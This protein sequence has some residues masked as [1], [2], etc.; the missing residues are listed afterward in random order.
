[1]PSPLVHTLLPTALAV[2]SPLRKKLSGADRIKFLL[3]CVVLGN[4][5]DFDLFPVLFDA[6]LWTVVHRWY[7]HNL[8]TFVGLALTGN[9]AFKKLLPQFSSRER[10]LCVLGLIASH[11]VLDGMV[12]PVVP[13]S[14]VPLWWPLSHQCLHMPFQLFPTMTR[15]ETMPGVLGY[16]VA[17]DNWKFVFG[18][19]LAMSVTLWLLLTL[20][21][22]LVGSRREREQGQD[23]R[24]DAGSFHGK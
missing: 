19:E 1:M 20:S 24:G 8:F 17:A 5:P 12:W 16:A 18:A 11:L 2:S 7:G 13:R 3:L 6:H 23:G 10:W 22:R 21:G 9:L 4:C 15:H 14:G